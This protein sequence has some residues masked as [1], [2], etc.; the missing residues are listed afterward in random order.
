MEGQEGLPNKG[1]TTRDNATTNVPMRQGTTLTGM[2]GHCTFAEYQFIEPM[3]QEMMLYSW[4]L[5][6]ATGYRGER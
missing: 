4:L 3:R 1:G 5:D 6:N 2:Q